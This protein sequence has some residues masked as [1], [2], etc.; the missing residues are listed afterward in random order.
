MRNALQQAEEA[1]VQLP[2]F[3]VRPVPVGGGI[4]DD[5]VVEV[6]AAF[7]ALH[8]FHRILHNPTD[9]VQAAGFHIPTCPGDDLLDAVEMGDVR[10]GRLCRKRCAPGVC[11]EVQ[12]FRTVAIRYPLHLPVDKLPVRGLFRE[13]AHVLE[14]GQAQT[15]AELR[16]VAIGSPGFS[17]IADIP[18]VIRL[19]MTLPGTA[20]L[21]RPGTGSLPALSGIAA[22][23]LGAGQFEGKIREPPPFRFR[24]TSVPQRFRLGTDGYDRTE[25]LQLL[26]AAAIQQLI[27]F[28]LLIREFYH[29]NQFICKYRYNKDTYPILFGKIL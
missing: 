19:L 5:A 28:P 21:D 13:N 29:G 11:E 6:A 15:Q 8:E 12:D 10:T 14:G 2:F 27:I 23:A 3:S 1:V 7:L 22:G 20:V 24:H 17:A 16:A 9:A 4:Q 18:L 25:P 26:T